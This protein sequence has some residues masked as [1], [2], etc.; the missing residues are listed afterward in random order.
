MKS[1]N[2][3]IL[4]ST[5]ALTFFFGGS[6]S[7]KILPALGEKV[8]VKIKT[9]R[10]S[11]DKPSTFIIQAPKGEF[12][13]ERVKGPHAQE[14]EYRIIYPNESTIYLSNRYLVGSHLNLENRI[15][16]GIKS[17]KRE[18][19]FDTLDVSGIQQNEHFWREV[20]LGDI[21]IGYVNVPEK[22]KELFDRSLESLNKR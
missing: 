1:I 13:E 11:L 22:S 20:I 5:L 21:V 3:L 19:I 8:R 16:A 6:C 15:R 17:Y 7:S 10:T 14:E 2:N 12:K 9:A 18:N 4:L